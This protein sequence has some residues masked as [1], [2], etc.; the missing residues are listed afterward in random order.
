MT[1]VKIC[2][3]TSEQDIR[4]CVEAG[5]NALGFVVEYPIDVP[6]NLDREKARELMS[7]VPPFVSRVI[8]VGDDPDLVVQLAKYLETPRGPAPRKGTASRDGRDRLLLK[9]PPPSLSSRPC[10]FPR[11]RGG[12][13]SRRTNRSTR[14]ALSKRPGWTC[15]FWIR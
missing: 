6:W 12:A 14:P 11:T 15:S 9:A 3:M 4:L 8:V 7:A 2:G 13:P 1:R 5:V 10:V